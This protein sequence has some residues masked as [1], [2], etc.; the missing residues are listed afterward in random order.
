MWI[1]AQCKMTKKSKNICGPLQSV[2]D[3]VRACV[4]GRACTRVSLRMKE[5][6][7]DVANKVTLLEVKNMYSLI[8]CRF[9]KSLFGPV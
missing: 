1:N 6:C 9:N 2:R 5:N 3:S 4:C 7:H 8:C